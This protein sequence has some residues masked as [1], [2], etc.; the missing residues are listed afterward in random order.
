MPICTK[1]LDYLEDTRSPNSTTATSTVTAA[2]LYDTAEASC[3]H[4]VNPTPESMKPFTN[5]DTND[6]NDDQVE[7]EDEDEELAICGDCGRV[8]GPGWQCSSCRRSCPHCNRALTTDPDDYC[9]R[10]FRKCVKHGIVYSLISGNGCPK[11]SKSTM[12]SRPSQ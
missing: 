9:G 5:Q 4:H 3:H 2:E 1:S 10:C 7:D 6:N 12:T 8:L 11:C